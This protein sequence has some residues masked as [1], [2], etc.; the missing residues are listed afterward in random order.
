MVGVRK[1]DF[2]LNRYG[3]EEGK[4]LYDQA[5]DSREKRA[6]RRSAGRQVKLTSNSDDD[7]REGRAIRCEACDFITT[8]LQW[9]HFKNKCSVKTIA[10]YRTLFP[11]SPLVAP[12]LTKVAAITRDSMIHLHGEEDG[13]L[14]YNEYRAKQ[15][16]TNTLEY[17]KAKYG[18]NEAEF[19]EYNASRATTLPNLIARHGEEEG[20]RK[21]EYYCE[22]QRYTTSYEYFVERY[23]YTEG[24]KRFDDYV[25][26]RSLKG[27]SL[28]E[29]IAYDTLR[30]HGIIDIEFQC[31]VAGIS[32]AFDM[33]SGN[34]LIEYHGTYWHADPRKYSSDFLNGHSGKSAENIWARD[35]KKVQK[36]I[37]AGYRVYTIWEAD[38][39]NDIANTIDYFIMWMNG[40]EQTGSSCSS[41]TNRAA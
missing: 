11:N 19:K 39:Q 21:W 30:A 31:R 33:R 32:G 15:A 18:M 7:L 5:L 40:T 23:G 20:I 16:E 37:E 29:E 14:R 12:A 8:R 3:E 10:E 26:A 36:A 2:Y 13:I 34:V 27:K 4:R 6:K 22:R 41:S 38:F 24:T 1:W 9:T 17:K 28:S 25:Y 35:S